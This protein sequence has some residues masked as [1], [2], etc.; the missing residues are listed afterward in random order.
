MKRDFLLF[1]VFSCLLWGELIFPFSTLKVDFI[2]HTEEETVKGRIYYYQGKTSVQIFSPLTQWMFLKENELL[3]Y[4]PNR[5]LAFKIKSASVMQIPFFSAFLYSVM[6]DFGLRE[7]GFVLAKEEEGE[8]GRISLWKKEK[9]GVL[10]QLKFVKLYFKGGKMIRVELLGDSEEIIS[11]MFFSKHREFFGLYFPLKIVIFR[12]RH[13]GKEEVLFEKP[14]FNAKIPEEVVN[15][16]LP[17]G[18]KV[19]E[20]RW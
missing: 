18:V 10:P 7:K 8:E 1:V 9:E 4:Y 6:E 19:D 15:F 3:I 11:R 5:K 12:C 20:I 14:L 13:K 17:E 2:R 16:R